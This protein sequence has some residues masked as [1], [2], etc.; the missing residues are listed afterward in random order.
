MVSYADS[1]ARISAIKKESCNWTSRPILINIAESLTNDDPRKNNPTKNIGHG[2]KVLHVG[3]RNAENC[4][5]MQ[6]SYDKK[7][8]DFRQTI[9]YPVI[10]S[11]CCYTSFKIHA[12]Y[13]KVYEKIYSNA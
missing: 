11:A 10:I 4:Y 8:E 3:T 2:K 13:Q 7:S 5:W 9:I 12:S 1:V 6:Q